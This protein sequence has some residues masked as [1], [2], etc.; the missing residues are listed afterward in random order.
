MANLTVREH[1]GLL[2]LKKEFES[3]FHHI[4]KHHVNQTGS[5]RTLFAVIP[6]IETW[7]DAK[8]EEFHVS[9]PVRG[10]KPKALNILLQGNQLTF[11]GER[12]DEGGKRQKN[13]LEREVSY[14]GF[15]RKVTLPD[16]VDG[17]KLKAELK[18]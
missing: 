12:K 10:M 9:V 7:I 13:Y 5:T 3:V 15:V 17:N 4:F 18:D 1:I 2:S 11:T 6:P 8:D 16:G 14:H